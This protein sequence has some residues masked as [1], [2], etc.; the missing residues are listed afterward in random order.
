MYGYQQYYNPYGSQ[1]NNAGSS[2]QG[3]QYQ[4]QIPNQQTIQQNNQ[5]QNSLSGWYVDCL[6]VTK[7]IN[8]DLTGNAMFFPST[9]GREIYKKQLDINTGKSITSIY[10]LENNINQSQNEIDFTPIYNRISEIKNEI[11]EQISEIK[12]MVLDSI[13]SPTIKKVGDK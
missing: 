5:P 7:S 4:N 11:S 2:Y 9:D 12:D 6:D 10:K 3:Y 13:T 1:F 8:A